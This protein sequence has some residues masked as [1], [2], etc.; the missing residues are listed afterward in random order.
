MNKNMKKTILKI[1]PVLFM[2]IFISGVAKAD[3]LV[4]VSKSRFG[5]YSFF[6]NTLTFQVDKP[7]YVAGEIITPVIYYYPY[8]STT[9][10]PVIN[11]VNTL[12]LYNG[13]YNGTYEFTIPTMTSFKTPMTISPGNYTLYAYL[14]DTTYRSATNTSHTYLYKNKSKFDLISFLGDMFI[15]KKAEACWMAITTCDE[16]G[17]CSTGP[18]PICNG[19]SGGITTNTSYLGYPI[20]MNTP[21]TIV[22]GSPKIFSK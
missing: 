3:T 7:A 14:S 2:I 11:E 4:D 21:F 13:D 6:K 1:V 16:F 20:V 12:S 22:A 18:T 10:T 8:A 5:N 9:A 15:P 17:N 19:I